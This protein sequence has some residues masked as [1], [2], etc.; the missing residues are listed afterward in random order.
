MVLDFSKDYKD[1]ERTQKEF[2]KTIESA[3]AHL[4]GYALIIESKTGYIPV[5]V[6]EIIDKLKLMVKN[7]KN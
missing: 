7:D 1:E 5:A 6:N 3:I 4:N 2:N